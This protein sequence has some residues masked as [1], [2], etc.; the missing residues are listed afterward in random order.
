MRNLIPVGVSNRHVHISKEDLYTLF[1]EGYELT[2]IKN[3]SQPGEFAAA[4]TV[5]IVGPKGQ[6]NKVRI[7]GP[8]REVT[9]VEVSKTDSF[10]LGVDAP[11]RMSGDLE[12]TPGVVL[13]GPKGEVK[14]EKGTVIA[15][16]HIHM[17][18][19]DAKQFGV[20]DKDIVHVKTL[21]DRGLIFDNVVVRVSN[22]YALDF[23]LD[24]DE[25]NAAGLKSGDMVELLSVRRLELM[26]A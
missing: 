4:E 6:I 24:T 14:C 7:L 21:G 22:S 19:S 13:V 9:Q 11:V 26:L 10:T 20:K 23:H 5:T 25:A 17:T 12:G 15:K 2:N 16:R 8:V 18:P 1:G 3:L